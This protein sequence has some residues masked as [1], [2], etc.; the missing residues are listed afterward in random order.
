MTPGSIKRGEVP[1]LEGKRVSLD[2]GHAQAD[3]VVERQDGTKF[4]LVEADAE[5]CHVC[6]GMDLDWDSFVSGVVLS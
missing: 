3:G 5:K 1:N 6:S 2:F 4:T